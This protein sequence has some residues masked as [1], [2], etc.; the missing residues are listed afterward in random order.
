MDNRPGEQRLHNAWWAAILLIVIVGFV[1]GTAAIFGGVFQSYIPVKLTA[2]RAGLVME[3]NARV[4]LRGVEVGRVKA[5]TPHHGTAELQ[6]EI[7]PDQIQFI[8]SNVEARIQATTV[9]GAKFVELVYP[10][11]P[12]PHHLAAGAVLHSQNVSTEVNTIF[13]NVSDLLKM[14]DPAKLN[15]ILTAVADGVRG[16]GPRMGEATTDL[17]EVLAVLNSRSDTIGQDWRSLKDFNNTYAAAASDIVSVLNNA[18][19]TATTIVDHSAQL[20]QL[21]T[22]VIGLST[23]GTDLLVASSKNLVGLV[24]TLE[25][26]TQ[27]LREYSPTY[28]CTLEGATW[29]LNH[30]GFDAWG[31][32]DGRSV[33]FDVGLLLG[34][35]PYQ[36]PDNL[37]IVAAKGGPGGKPGCGSLPDVSKNF[38]VRQMVTNT[39]WGTG[40]DIRPNPGLGHPCWADYFPVTRAVP[41]PP[42]IRQCL[43]GP[44]PGPIP[45]PGA[46][47][48]GA[49]LYGPGG[50]PL[51][52]GVPPA[53]PGSVQTGVPAPTPAAPPALPAEAPLPPAAPPPPPGAGVPAP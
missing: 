17:K 33:Q 1:S 5:V 43:P 13:Q 45:Y 4:K 27:L 21:L 14:I 41:A 47:P 6:L 19:T 48:Y 32:H 51:W 7:Y 11:D 9:F 28:A 46:P 29:Y 15:A 23:S 16:Q 30:G 52:P 40:L 53:E 18:A 12:S 24:D 3:T 42:S 25:P 31:G 39:G 8:P 26:T 20:D 44:A 37:P 38:P 36:Y 10:P 34:N 50:V 49:A 35:D 22:N 2:E